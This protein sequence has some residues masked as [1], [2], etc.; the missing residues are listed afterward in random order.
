MPFVMI[1]AVAQDNASPVQPANHSHNFLLHT[2][3]L[4]VDLGTVGPGT[5]KKATSKMITAGAIRA[6]TT[7]TVVE[8]VSLIL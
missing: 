6:T 8:I 7:R 2:K 1:Q 4:G 3:D 5:S